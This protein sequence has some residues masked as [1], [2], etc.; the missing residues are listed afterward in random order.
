MKILLAE[1][2]RSTYF[3]RSSLKHLWRQYFQYGF[4]KVRVL[5]KH[6]RQMS[7]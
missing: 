4:W 1:D 2:V 7:L 5:Q 3:S 6:P